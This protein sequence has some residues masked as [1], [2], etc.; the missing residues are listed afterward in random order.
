MLTPEALITVLTNIVLPSALV[1]FL[2]F[3]PSLI[4]WKKPRDLGPRPI[5]GFFKMEMENVTSKSALLDLDQDFDD[6][7]APKGFNFPVF[8]SNIEA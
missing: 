3:V 8:L 7:L 2:T 4:E 5:P 6:Q 1:I